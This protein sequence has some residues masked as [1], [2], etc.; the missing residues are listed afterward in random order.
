MKW[1]HLRTYLVL[2]CLAATG[3][4]LSP[5]PAADSAPQVEVNSAVPDTAEQGTVSL[6]VTINGR[7]FDNGSTVAFFVHDT[8]DNNGGVSVKSVAFQSSKKLV[9]TINVSSDAQLMKKLDIQVETS[10][11]RRGKGIEKFQVIEKIH[12]KCGDAV[13][14]GQE[15][16]TCPRDCGSAQPDP[17]LLATVSGI[18]V[19]AEGYFGEY[20]VCGADLD[21]NGIPEVVVGDPGADKVFVFSAEKNTITNRIELNELPEYSVAGSGG[22]F[23][24]WV[25]NAGDF[26]G[27][28]REDIVVGAPYFA[29]GKRRRDKNV[30]KAY[31]YGGGP[32]GII[33][34]PLLELEGEVGFAYFGRAVDGAGDFNGDG[35]DD[36]VVGAAE[37]SVGE[38]G[39]VYVF[40]GTCATA[41]FPGERIF[42]CQG[43]SKQDPGALG[44]SVAGGLEV[45]SCDADAIV[46]GGYYDPG[47]DRDIVFA[48]CGVKDGAHFSSC[49]QDSRAIIFD[50]ISDPPGTPG[51]FGQR[52]AA[53]GNF[54]G[55][56]VGNFEIAISNPVPFS[57]T[58]YGWVFVCD[59]STSSCVQVD[60]GDQ[61]GDRLGS[62]LSS[63]D[64]NG[65]GYA[66]VVAGGS[67][68]YAGDGDLTTMVRVTFGGGNP[69]NDSFVRRS[70]LPNTQFG[71][72]V[73]GETDFTG[74][75]V[76]DIL[77]GAHRD[78]D[79]GKVYLYSVAAECGDVG[80]DGDPICGEDEQGVDSNGDLYCPE[81][82]PSSS[83]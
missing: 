8:E 50:A 63:G 36:I 81:D 14:Q 82:C 72:A 75:G 53:V 37:S 78:A 83:P 47:S 35:C 61:V 52:V 15:Q 4:L 34:Q 19:G 16:L 3:F 66:D 31:V 69:G 64:F 27:D 29:R 9:A 51:V 65:D 45:D 38:G 80:W 49:Q 7:G 71:R 23:G 58:S 59:A 25:A 22:N 67:V 41:D 48:Y 54:D 77:V 42:A 6:P 60:D 5:T 73:S 76:N 55:D 57:D 33:E 70:I 32:T 30:G 18:E 17:E 44:L 21:G 56:A 1:K 20:G 39:W 68:D 40:S 74:D 26:D 10:R 12:P 62:S 28:G 13:C 43:P 79:G 11:G 46:A 24:F 2:A